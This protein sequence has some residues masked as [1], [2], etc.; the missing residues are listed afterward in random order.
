MKSLSLKG[1]WYLPS[2]PRKK[3]FGLLK[4]DSNSGTS[5]ELH[6]PLTPFSGAFGEEGIILGKTDGGDVTLVKC[7]QTHRGRGETFTA[8]FILIGALFKSQEDIVF[9]SVDVE[10]ENLFQWLSTKQ[11]NIEQDD[12]ETSFYTIKVQGIDDIKLVDNQEYLSSIKFGYTIKNEQ[13]EIR[14]SESAIYNLKTTKSKVDLITFINHIQAFQ[15]ILTIMT[16]APC[17]TID[18]KFK[19]RNKI[20]E[21]YYNSSIIPSKSPFRFHDA[22][23]PY[24]SIK[25]DIHNII[26]NYTEKAKELDSIIN[27][28]TTNINYQSKF[29]EDKFLNVV[30]GIETFHRRFRK[31]EISNEKEEM[32]TDILN[33]IPDKHKQWFEGRLS[34]FL[35]PSL[36][37]R[38]SSIITE[39][40]NGV[41]SQLI[42]SPSKFIKNIKNSR[43]YYTHYSSEKKRAALKGAELFNATRT[44]DFI[45]TFCILTE[46]GVPVE[47]L[48]KSLERLKYK[49]FY[50]LLVKKAGSK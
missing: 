50:N 44:L 40:H 2:N 32:I 35:Q 46:I 6:E 10:F 34:S 24:N 41:F 38:L 3:R 19:T 16:H 36:Q 49:W 45:L 9:N 20:I 13:Q 43:D 12:I 21:M 30:Q 48:Q 25:D 7:F 17:P 28:I 42:E 26:I 22:I 47:V 8:M 37:D 1:K 23:L 11:V 33:S 15:K 14:I 18:I 27:L 39:F 29:S 31:N 5:L 4:Y